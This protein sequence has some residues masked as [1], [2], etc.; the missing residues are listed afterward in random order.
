[1]ALRPGDDRLRVPAL[2]G[3]RLPDPHALADGHRAAH[4]RRRRLDQWLAADFRCDCS[5]TVADVT[6]FATGEPGSGRPRRE[7]A[8]RPDG[9]QKP[10]KPQPRQH[11]RAREEKFSSAPGAG[12]GLGRPVTLSY[13]HQ[14]RRRLP[15][16]RSLFMR[17][18]VPSG[19]SFGH[20]A[21]HSPMFVHDPKPSCS[22]ASTIAMTRRVPLGLALW[23]KPQV[24]DL[25][26][27]EQHRRR[28]RD[29]RPRRRRSRCTR[30]TRTPRRRRLS[31]SGSKRASGAAPVLTDTKPPAAMMRSN[32]TSVDDEILEYGERT[33]APRLDP[34]LLA[35]LEVAHVQ[36]A[37][38]RGA[39][40]SVGDAVDNETAHAADAFAAVVV[41][42]D[43]VFAVGDQ[44]LVH[45]VEHFEERHVFALMPLAG[46]DIIRPRRVGV[47]P[48]ATHA[49]IR[50]TCR[51]RA[52]G[53]RSRR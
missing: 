20:A 1:M 30:R 17:A 16:R 4:V 53:G 36:L 13:D 47:R 12:I 7:A 15:A 52:P 27:G 24:G 8:V 44:A 38:G 41:E 33:G 48:A 19:I 45:D 29:T 25:G 35:V 28:V 40:G 26:R 23:Q 9:P 42:G 11:V 10:Q 18:M 5:L 34:Q 43:R 6:A 22:I 31:G 14:V 2:G 21:E 32:G 49:E 37:C 3:S 39:L 46:Y 50:F 51:L